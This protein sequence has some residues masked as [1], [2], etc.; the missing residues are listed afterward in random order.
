MAKIDMDSIYNS[1]KKAHSQAKDAEKNRGKWAILYNRIQ[2]EK[3]AVRFMPMPGSSCGF[4]EKNIKFHSIK[5]EDGKF[6]KVM[7]QE[8][9]GKKCR[10]CALKEK[11]SK[12]ITDQIRSIG[13]GMVKEKNP[14]NDTMIHNFDKAMILVMAPSAMDKCNAA[15]QDDDDGGFNIK[16]YINISKKC[17]VIRVQKLGELLQTE[18]NIYPLDKAF[19]FDEKLIKDAI[20]LAE[21]YME[22]LAE[23]YCE[24]SSP[25]KEDEDEV[26]TPKKE[27]KSSKT[28]KKSTKDEVEELL[29][30]E[31]EDEDDFELEDEEEEEEEETPKKKA[32]KS[33]AAKEET[34][35]KKASKEEDED[36]EL[37][38]DIDELELDEDLLE[39]EDDED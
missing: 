14:K 24:S 26:E 25:G 22:K 11:G 35:K 34:P 17:K 15:L 23:L 30:G 31:E 29:D 4:F 3:I 27:K 6:K 1:A 32:K 10:Y 38:V 18:Y 16:D 28:T 21:N 8:H 12:R 19:T 37:D 39:D 5:S 13:I 7:C 20:A 2:S 9:F 36:D 33:K